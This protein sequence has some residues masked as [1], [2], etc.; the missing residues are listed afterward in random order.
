[1]GSLQRLTVKVF[2]N[3][4]FYNVPVYKD[5]VNVVTV[6]L[7]VYYGARLRGAH[8]N[9]YTSLKHLIFD[10]LRLNRC[11]GCTPEVMGFLTD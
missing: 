4:P 7:R 8:N 10:Y 3:L 9:F 5:F 2:V 11:R 6:V 1:M